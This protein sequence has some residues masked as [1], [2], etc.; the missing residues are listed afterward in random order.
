VR[1]RDL[2]LGEGQVLAGTEEIAEL[3]GQLNQ[4]V[5]RI[6]V[7]IHEGGL[8]DAEWYSFSVNAQHGYPRSR[9]DVSR[10]LGRIFGDP[11]W[12]AKGLREISRHCAIPKST[13]SDHYR[14]ITS[15][16]RPGQLGNKPSMR[17]AT[18]ADGTTY[19]IETGQIGKRPN[20][21]AFHDG[22]GWH[23]TDIEDFTR[24]PLAKIQDMEEEPDD[25]EEED[26]RHRAVAAVRS[27]FMAELQTVQR[28]QSTTRT[29]NHPATG[30]PTAMKTSGIG[31]LQ[32]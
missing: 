31:R 30:Q 15:S 18:R 25:E 8:R 21:N 26:E 7:E 6:A 29:Y 13:V 4:D 24:D 20:G 12:S 9:A 27:E 10:I 5:T 22:T 17:E 1:N 2:K 3:L 11:V 19:E 14:K 28:G 32:I 16:V 23:Q